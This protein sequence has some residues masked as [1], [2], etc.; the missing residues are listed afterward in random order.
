MT[1]PFR[2]GEAMTHEKFSIPMP[3]ILEIKM[4]PSKSQPGKVRVEAMMDLPAAHIGLEVRSYYEASEFPPDPRQFLIDQANLSICQLFHNLIS[5]KRQD[6]QRPEAQS[7]S[8]DRISQL[9]AE[10]AD[11]R[12]KYDALYL[13]KLNITKEPS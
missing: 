3:C 4:A 7:C 12:T 2:K 13:G 6:A 1:Y 8:A 5:A 10:L 9:E 11:L